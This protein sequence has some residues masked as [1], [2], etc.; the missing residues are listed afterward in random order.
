M[1][2]RACVCVCIA[3]SNSHHRPASSERRGGQLRERKFRV[4]LP[5]SLVFS[6]PHS[7]RYVWPL[8]MKLNLRAGGLSIHL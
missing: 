6:L 5:L 2:V 1:C 8:N 3:W 4:I 7:S